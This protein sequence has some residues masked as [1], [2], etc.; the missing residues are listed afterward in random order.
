MPASTSY[1]KVN[2]VRR[3]FLPLAFCTDT[4]RCFL[5]PYLFFP[6]TGPARWDPNIHEHKNKILTVHHGS[7][8]QHLLT[9]S[10]IGK[11]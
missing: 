6:G 9:T 11:L 5:S 2:S 7:D 10:Y 8:A 3:A 4:V 1:R